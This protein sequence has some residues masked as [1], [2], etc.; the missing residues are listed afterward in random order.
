MTDGTLAVD[1]GLGPRAS[2]TRQ[3]IIDTARALFLDRGYAGTSVVDIT[4]ACGI[5]RAGFYTYFRDKREVFSELGRASY[6]SALSVVDQLADLPELWSAD[7]VRDWVRRYFAH[8]DTH[9]AFVLAATLSAPPEADFRAD[10]HRTQMRF[11]R[12]LGALLHE[13]RQEP[14]GSP[15]AIGLVVVSLL[16]RC[17][18]QIRVNKV[19][20][21]ETD[22]IDEATDMIVRLVNQPEAPAAR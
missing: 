19:E 12:R 4:E 20:V 15:E 7:D 8:M 13:R 1:P 5:S 22:L 2:R 10:S 9:G 17:W 14:T 11:A 16:E 3:A 6:R 21:A 18:F